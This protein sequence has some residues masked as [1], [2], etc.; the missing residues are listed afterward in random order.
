M[1]EILPWGNINSNTV[2]VGLEPNENHNFKSKH[3]FCFDL[4]IENDGKSGGV[5]KKMFKEI[6]K[7][8]DDYFWTNFKKRN[9]ELGEESAIKFIDF[10]LQYPFE[11]Y[12]FL[13]KKLAMLVHDFKIDL[14]LAGKKVYY[15]RH[16]AY[17]LYKPGITN[18]IRSWE[19]ALK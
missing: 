3:I 5:L 7:N 14:L 9:N 8:I 18:Y 17:F 2:I 11:R 13:G 6:N 1:R 12:I 19:E 10:I 4:D 16:P 15:L